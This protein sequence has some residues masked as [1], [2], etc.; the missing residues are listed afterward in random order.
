MDC[1]NKGMASKWQKIMDVIYQVRW[2]V[3]KQQINFYCDVII[4]IEEREGGGGGTVITVEA[5]VH[6]GDEEDEDS[7]VNE[8]EGNYSDEISSLML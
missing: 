1:V 2:G 4:G 6:A 8:K 7:D 3:G 5:D